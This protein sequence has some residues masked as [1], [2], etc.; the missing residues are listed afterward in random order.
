MDPKDRENHLYETGKRVEIRTVEE[1]LLSFF[2]VRSKR[3]FKGIDIGCGT[4]EITN[5][6]MEAGYDCVGFDFSPLQSSLPVRV[7]P[8]ILTFVIWTVASSGR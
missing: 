6:M 8:V 5:H 2:N 3:G 1:L 7:L 4:G